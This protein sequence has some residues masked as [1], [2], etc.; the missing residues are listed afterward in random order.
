MNSRAGF[1]ILA[2]A[3]AVVFFALV[4]GLGGAKGAAGRTGGR[5]AVP[6]R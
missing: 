1:V 5:V 4:D 6:G 3:A 2:V